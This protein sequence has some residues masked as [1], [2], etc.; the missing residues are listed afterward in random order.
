M[1]G[2]F[3]TFEGPEGSG[4]TT[5]IL[6]LAAELETDGLAVV[7]TREPGGTTVGERIRGLLLDLD[8]GPLQPET[9]VLLFCAARAELL[10]HVIR[11]ALA[12]GHLVLCDRYADATRAY[13]GHGRGLDAERIEAIN[14]QATGGLEPD[15][16]LLLDLPVERG[17]ARRRREGEAWNRFDAAS[18]AFHQR[19]RQGYLELAAAAPERFVIV[20]ADRP[21]GAVF[22]DL[23]GALE[24]ALRRAGLRLPLPEE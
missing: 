15:L 7:A 6:R 11:P 8:G 2:V 13:Q 4:K 1:P 3:V 9:E 16:T 17:L 10:A 20:D 21:P 18:L 5:Q 24:P 22:E 19:V 23:R 14:R 12:T